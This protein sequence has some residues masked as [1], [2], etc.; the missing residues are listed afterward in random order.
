MKNP[1]KITFRITS[2]DIIHGFQIVSASINVMIFPGCF[3]IITWIPPEDAKGEFLIVCNEYCGTNVMYA[4][5]I[6]ER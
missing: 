2:A 5:L 3:T 1:K 6:I 4:K